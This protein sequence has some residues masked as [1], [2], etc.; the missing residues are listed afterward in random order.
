MFIKTESGTYIN[1][2]NIVSI[3]VEGEVMC[4]ILAET[5]DRKCYVLTDNI[6]SVDEANAE[7]KA[8]IAKIQIWTD[9]DM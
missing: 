2:N 8:I 4:Q 9:G 3:F 1:T 6:K 5:V 7:L